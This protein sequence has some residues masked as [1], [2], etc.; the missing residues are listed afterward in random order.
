MAIFI[1]LWY[2]SNSATLSCSS[3]VTLL[4]YHMYYVSENGFEA[5]DSCSFGSLVD[6]FRFLHRFVPLPCG[7]QFFLSTSSQLLWKWNVF[8]RRVSIIIYVYSNIYHRYSTTD[9]WIIY[10]TN[11]QFWADWGSRGCRERK[12]QTAISLQ[13]LRSVFIMFSRLKNIFKKYYIVRT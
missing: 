10:K 13:L 12:V 3:E 4:L 6:K 8:L 1:D 11:D 2:C 9:H 5:G 7:A